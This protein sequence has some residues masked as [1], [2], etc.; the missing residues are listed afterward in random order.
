[1]RRGALRWRFGRW[2]L[3]AVLVT[4]SALGL[5]T[6]AAAAPGGWAQTGSLGNARESHS[7][8][9]LFEGKVLVAGGSGLASAELFDPDKGT[10]AAT[11]SLATARSSHT[12][13][14]ISN[15]PPACQ[16]NCRKVLVAGG[17]GSNGLPLASAELFDL[18]SGTWT[19]T[20]ALATARSS[21]TATLLSN[22]SILVVGGM[23]ASQQPLAGA[24]L[25]SPATGT[26]T[27]TAPLATART[28]H[29]ATLLADGKVLVAGGVGPGGQPLASAE[30]YDP[31]ANSGAG[32]WTPTGSLNDARTAQSA[33]P[34]GDEISGSSDRRVLV[35][36]GTGP[37]GSPLASAEIYNPQSGSWTRTGSLA[38]PRALHTAAL[39][40]DGKVVVAGG[41]GTAGRLA[42]AELFSPAAGTWAPTGSLAAPRSVHRATVLLDGRVLLTGGSGPAG[43]PLPTAELYSPS[44]G[45]RWE[46]TASMAGARSAHT[47][48]LL[49]NGDVL[50]AGGH[51]T[52]D[53]FLSAGPGCCNTAPLATAERYHPLSGTWSPT[54]MLARARSFHTATLLR[55]SPE[56]CGT[57]CGKVLV[58]GGFGAVDPAGPTGNAEALA[59]AELYD[60]ATGQWSPTG[61]MTGRRAWH[62]ATLL[63]SGRVLVAGGSKSAGGG[64]A[65][66]TAELYDPVSGTWTPTGRLIAGGNP[67]RSGPQGAR[68]N[69]AATLLTGSPSQCG[70]NCGKVLVVGGT[71]GSGSG[72]A[73]S[74]AELYDPARGTFQQTG[75]LREARQLQADAATLLPNG[76]VLV[77]GGFNSPFTTAPPHLNTAEL[78]DPVT[79]TWTPTGVLGSRRLYQS[80]TLLPG[81][82][83]LAAGGLAGG[84]APAFPYKPGPA[85]VSSEAYDPANGGWSASSFLNE[86][87]LQ[88]TATLL[89]SGPPSVCGENC[90][91]VLVAGGDRELIGNFIPAARYANPLSSAELYGPKPVATSTPTPMPTPTPTV[92]VDNVPTPTSP[93]AVRRRPGLAVEVRPSRDRRPPY[94]FTTR[95]RLRLPSGVGRSRGC[96]GTVRVTVK[97]KGRG[98]TSSSRR[99]RVGGSCAFQSRV[100][101]KSSRRLGVSR[102]TLRFIVRFQG[103]AALKPRTVVRVA[104]YG[105]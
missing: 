103:N 43:Q 37:G 70:S 85:L 95:G 71:G 22:G 90:S 93:K 59:S 98:K 63:A 91:R 5:E 68:Q 74:S 57:N 24:E 44:L 75:G 73:F 16:P 56:Q 52:F 39:L 12:A 30:V 102:G 27:A 32:A 97:R 76:K 87:R 1:M 96:K 54:G 38:D 2:T 15:R 13:T 86:G 72:A 18:G 67:N 61:S 8:T 53:F 82:R 84:N 46:P 62:T 9:R 100:T 36:G 4:S 105:R 29:T 80:Q 66:D 41:S 26:W 47:A 104:R 20:G 49:L 48:T 51:T 33:T 23:G 34:L 92:T 101:F 28:A 14:L 10:W 40:P 25:F 78:Y 60:P 19:P 6:R 7:S 31:A 55:G 79:E 50:V 83:V 69:H 21:H 89:P 65:I 35:A 3:L 94:R 11:G 81:G 99:A 88:H 58:A 77:V 42:S 45:D 17:V 64:D